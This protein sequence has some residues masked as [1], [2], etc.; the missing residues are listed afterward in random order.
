[1]PVCDRQQK[2]ASEVTLDEHMDL[3]L[4]SCGIVVTVQNLDA[5]SNI[6]QGA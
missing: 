2:V 3:S 1:M 4:L 6:L 5:L